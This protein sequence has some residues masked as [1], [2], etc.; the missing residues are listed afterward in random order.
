MLLMKSQVGTCAFPKQCQGFQLPAFAICAASSSSMPGI[1]HVQGQHHTNSGQSSHWRLNTFY[2]RLTQFL[3]LATTR[4]TTSVAEQ[5]DNYLYSFSHAQ[6]N[7]AL[8]PYLATSHQIWLHTF[9][10]CGCIVVHG[11]GS[12]STKSQ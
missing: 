6:C 12:A 5:S 9:A 11:L 8:R 4:A 10:E 1:S 3:A 2:E 7:C